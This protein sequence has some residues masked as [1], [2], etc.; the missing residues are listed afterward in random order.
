MVIGVGGFLG[1]GEKN[2]AVPPDSLNITRKPDSSPIDKISVTYTKDQLK[3]APIFAH[4][5]TS[6]AQTTGSGVIDSIKALNPI[7]YPK[8]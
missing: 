8:K 3:S 7:S 1:V 6:K 4:D 2:V 5:E